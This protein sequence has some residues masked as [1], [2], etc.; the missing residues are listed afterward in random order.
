MDEKACLCGAIGCLVRRPKKMSQTEWAKRKYASG[1]CRKRAE[2]QRYASDERIAK[3]QQ[4]R[5]DNPDMPIVAIARS[6]CMDA[7]R[8]QGALE[9]AD[10]NHHANRAGRHSHSTNTFAAPD[11]YD[12]P[13]GR[14]VAQRQAHGIIV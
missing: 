3:A 12:R 10:L 13:C 14:I 5:R 9:E 1:E 7:K 4:M 11:W 6:L 2:Q 8:V